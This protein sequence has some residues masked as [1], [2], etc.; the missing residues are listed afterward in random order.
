[1]NWRVK[2]NNEN[3][4]PNNRRSKEEVRE[5]S[6]KGGIKSGE[7]RREKKT[8]KDTLKMLLALPIKDETTKEMLSSIGIAEKDMTRQITVCLG[9]LKAADNGSY[10]SLD[11]I[12]TLLGEKIT[13]V[14]VSG[15]TSPVIEE[16]DKLLDKKE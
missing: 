9:A 11:T 10:K 12:A 14:E 2:V 15:D 5:H 8:L 13:K 7:V 3:L 6:R 4:I 16:I 1:M